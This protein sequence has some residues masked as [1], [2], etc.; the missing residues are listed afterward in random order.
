MRDV[1][2]AMEEVFVLGRDGR[3]WSPSGFS[4]EFWLRYASVFEKVFAIVRVRNGDPPAGAAQ[5]PEH[6]SI[7]ALPAYKGLIG[8]MLFVP[9]LMLRFFFLSRS[10][11]YFLRAPGVIA[12]SLGLVLSLRKVPY[13]VELV[14]DIDD[15]LHV[16]LPKRIY[17]LIRHLVLGIS[18]YVVRKAKGVA[19]VTASTLQ[20][21]YPC[22]IDAL[23]AS[24]SSVSIDYVAERSAPPSD[25]ETI[26]IISVGTFSKSYKGFDTIIRAVKSMV[27]KAIKV[28]LVIVG[29]GDHLGQ[30]VALSESLG[31]SGV[32]VFTGK[33]PRDEVLKYMDIANVYVS[34]SRTEGLPRVIVEAM[35]R[36]LPVISTPVGGCAE[37]VLPDYLF[38]V[39][40][41]DAL[42]DKV[43]SLFSSDA[44]WLES[45]SYSRSVAHDFLR[46]RV[47]GNRIA[48]ME[49]L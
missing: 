19:Y 23:S 47:E 41:V 36:S 48:F 9:L 4:S 18:R 1:A 11:L 21:K 40:N 38:P 46:E 29:D 42:V 25:C 7:I 27:G 16:L 45:M 35:S 43:E 37:I 44:A 17:F 49:R 20:L 28:E 10:R 12:M 34:A 26:K 3:Y 33:I 15:V 8:S 5:V 6:I 22:G 2:I 31:L 30:H 39:D 32:V 14:G 13:A 24:Y